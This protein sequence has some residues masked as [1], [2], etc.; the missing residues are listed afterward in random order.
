MNETSLPEML[1]WL[2]RTGYQVSDLTCWPDRI[3]TRDLD[4][5]NV[6]HV[7]GTKGKGSTCAFV[8]SMM[9][10]VRKADGKHY[11]VGLFTSPHLKSVRERIQIDGQPIP[12]PLFA[13]YFFKVWD[14]LEAAARK[15]GEP[16]SNKPVYFRYLTL[17]SWITF[18]E[19]NVSNFHLLA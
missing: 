12:E 16:T 4:K 18:L 13:K 19:E 1:E 8:S 3:K 11:K 17:M 2:R 5:L 7:T 15:A 9:R 6:V 10:T 14:A